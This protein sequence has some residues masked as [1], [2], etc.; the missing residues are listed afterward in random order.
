LSVAGK[1][2]APSLFGPLDWKA[3]DS[4]GFLFKNMNSPEDR[5]EARAGLETGAE[6]HDK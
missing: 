4:E 3:F 6:P 2:F 1:I 5:G